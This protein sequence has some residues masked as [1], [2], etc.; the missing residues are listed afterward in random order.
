M[1]YVHGQS[2]AAKE[3]QKAEEAARAKVAKLAALNAELDQR[4]KAREQ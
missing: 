2:I 1:T 4:I 3:A